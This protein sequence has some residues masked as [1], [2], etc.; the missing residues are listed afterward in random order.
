[1]NKAEQ[2]VFNICRKSFLSLWSYL[3]P[4]G[5]NAKELCD[6]LVVCE[7]DLIIFSVKDIQI[8]E[9]GDDARDWSR[10]TRKAIDESSKQI[11]GAERWLKTAATVIRNDGTP[12]L[13]LP[14]LTERRVHRIAV[15]FG[16]KNKVPLVFGDFGKGF[17]HV[18]D[19]TSFD[20]VMGELN[21]ITDFVTYLTAK[22]EL[23]AA[24][25]RID[26]F[27][28]EED[29]MALY[30]NNGRRFP[31]GFTHYVV[32]GPIWETFIKKPEYKKKQK[33]DRASLMWDGLIEKFAEDILGDNLEF[34]GP[35]TKAEKG[36]RIM[37]RE[38][39]FSRRILGKS[40]SDFYLLTKTKYGSRITPAPSGVIYVFLALPHRTER[41]HRIAVL[42]T[43]CFVARGLNPTSHHVLGIATEQDKP[44]KGFSLDLHYLYLPYWNKKLQTA[45][46]RMQRDLGYFTKPS[47]KVGDEDEYP[48]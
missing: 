45:F 27:S 20:I 32:T 5:K 4:T 12:G 25:T 23:V 18:F 43:R 35:L 1:M 42:G 44:G 9:S 46:K 7:P 3:R 22:E 26:N 15:A 17:I 24:G 31:Q 28:A 30:L 8:K 19:E 2:L 36:I 48:K 6:V 10:W 14:T 11:Y 34:G 47:K 39:R 13:T 37:A 33:A 40:F 29:L 16:G 41:K 38:D 21:T